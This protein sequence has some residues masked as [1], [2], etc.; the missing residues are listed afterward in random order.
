VST[1]RFVNLGMGRLEVLLPRPFLKRW[2]SMGEAQGSRSR[3]FLVIT[4]TYEHT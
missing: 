2:G 1:K 3:S 4:R